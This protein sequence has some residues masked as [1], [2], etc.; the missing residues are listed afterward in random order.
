MIDEAKIIVDQTFDI[1]TKLH[2]LANDMVAMFLLLP[3]MTLKSLN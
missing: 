3:K 1:E 2:H